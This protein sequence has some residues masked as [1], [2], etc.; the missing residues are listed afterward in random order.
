MNRGLATL[1]TTLLVALPLSGCGADASSSDGG[2]QQRDPYAVTEEPTIDVDQLDPPSDYSTIEGSGFTIAAP[3]EFQQQTSTS[4]NGE[5]RLV[6]EKPSSVQQVPQRVVVIRDVEPAK[7]AEEQSFALETWKAA[8]DKDEE[9]TVHRYRLD[10]PD[11][12]QA[13]LVTWDEAQAGRRTSDVQVTYWQLM[14]QVDDDLI[15]NV[16][17]FAPAAEFETSEVS[18][19]LRTFQ[20]SS[21][22]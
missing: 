21:G 2:A 15:I 19:I 7:D 8:G 13:F 4:P 6:L 12:Q 1:V 10:A 18:R 14:W 5:P 22:A 3:G 11:G 16:V 17:A 20:P 9:S